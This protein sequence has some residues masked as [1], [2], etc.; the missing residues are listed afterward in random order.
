[1]QQFLPVTVALCLG[2]LALPCLGRPP[3]E[4]RVIDKHSGDASISSMAIGAHPDSPLVVGG[5]FTTLGGVAVDRL[6]KIH[7]GRITDVGGGVSGTTGYGSA[8]VSSVVA[9]YEQQA[10]EPLTLVGG[11]FTQAG[12]QD[13]SCIA[14]WNGRQWITFHGGVSG[15]DHA[16]V[17]SVVLASCRRLLAEAA[18]ASEGECT[19]LRFFVGGQF[20]KAGAVDVAGLAEWKSDGWH[21]LPGLHARHVSAMCLWT[22]GP[23]DNGSYLVVAGDLWLRGQG[24]CSVALWDGVSWSRS[25]EIAGAHASLIRSLC[26]A[27]HS[28]DD[29]DTLMSVGVV[30]LSKARDVAS[31]AVLTKCR[32]AAWESAYRLAIPAGSVPECIASVPVREQNGGGSRLLVAGRGDTSSEANPLLWQVSPS[33]SLIKT[34]SARI[35]G[36]V[37]AVLSNSDGSAWIGGRLY[38][39]EVLTPAIL[40]SPSASGAD[41]HEP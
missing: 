17:R 11:N 19:Q 29:G 41:E 18:S 33:Y 10:H 39:N 27:P 5:T 3:Q 31:Q 24:E 15:A 26:V 36:H 1:M 12:A 16:S 6:A 7:A 21:P 14:A 25:D 20:K 28:C 40:I 35:R 34:H 32:D 4:W 2:T 38:L 22:P 8:Y 9:V 23:R 30:F 37:L 13:A